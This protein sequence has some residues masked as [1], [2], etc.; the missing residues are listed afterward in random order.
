MKKPFYAPRSDAYTPRFEREHPF[1]GASMAQI[2]IK[3]FLI[4]F[5]SEVSNG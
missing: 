3:S 4:A 1:T 2:A 5:L